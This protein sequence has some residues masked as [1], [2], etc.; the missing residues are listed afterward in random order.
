MAVQGRPP[1][2]LALHDAEGT[3]RDDRHGD[4]AET[5][6]FDGVPK[7]PAK[8]DG[9]AKEFWDTYV[10]RLVKKG[11]AK[12]IDSP[13]LELMCFA[14]GRLKAMEKLVIKEPEDRVLTLQFIKWAGL[15]NELSGKFGMNPQDLAR[16]RVPKKEKKG[17]STRKRA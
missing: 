8:L 5:V 1:K 16:L 12:T 9:E 2:P 3:W 4:P 13:A 6:E 7:R 14:W 15:F 10:P 17:I 11:L